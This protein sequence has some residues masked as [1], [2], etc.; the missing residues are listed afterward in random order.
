MALMTKDRHFICY[1]QTS[2]GF[3]P[4]QHVRLKST[5]EPD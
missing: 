1:R 2:S 4:G 3:H 5:I